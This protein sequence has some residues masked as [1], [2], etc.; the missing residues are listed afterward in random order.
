[1][2]S[3][4]TV[5]AAVTN[6]ADR[7]PPRVKNLDLNYDPFFFNPVGRAFKVAVNKRF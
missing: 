3:N 1:M 4:L 6:V 7:D 2:P 5:T